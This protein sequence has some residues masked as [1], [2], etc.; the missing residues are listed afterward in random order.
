MTS[1]NTQ[2]ANAL[3]PTTDPFEAAARAFER[4]CTECG[5]PASAVL[6]GRAVCVACKTDLTT[7][8]EEVPDGE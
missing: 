1:G 4:T 6:D 3:L 5:A 2:P 8:A 7:P